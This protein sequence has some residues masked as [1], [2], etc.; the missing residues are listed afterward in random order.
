MLLPHHLLIICRIF[1]FAICLKLS[2]S[3]RGNVE[4]AVSVP[5]IKFSNYSL[6]PVHDKLYCN[7]FLSRLISEVFGLKSISYMLNI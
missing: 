3:C 7:P 4:L 6:G 1:I 5:V 2:W